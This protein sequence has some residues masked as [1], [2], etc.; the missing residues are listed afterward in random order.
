MT[1]INGLKCKKKILND[2]PSARYTILHCRVARFG[3]LRIDSVSKGCEMFLVILLM[4]MPLF[5]LNVWSGANCDYHERLFV[6]LH[7]VGSANTDSDPICDSLC[8]Y[9]DKMATDFIA[10]HRC[11]FSCEPFL[12]PKYHNNQDIINSITRL[13]LSLPCIFL[14]NISELLWFCIAIKSD[15]WSVISEPSLKFLIANHCVVNMTQKNINY[16]LKFKYLLGSL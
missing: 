16:V 6:D 5:H 7:A 2:R 3:K 14:E 9:V 15:Q 12:C 8:R 13:L 10:W 11:V 4:L 1:Y